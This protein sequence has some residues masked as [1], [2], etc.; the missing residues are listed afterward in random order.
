MKAELKHD[1][2]GA[3]RSG[4]YI[5]GRE[6][7]RSTNGAGI[8]QFCCLGVLCDLSGL[9]QWTQDEGDACYHVSDS[10]FTSTFNGEMCD[11]LGLDQKIMHTLW[12]KNDGVMTENRHTFN[13]IADYIEENVEVTP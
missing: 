2:V 10:M 12:H 9:G 3:L 11:I 1:W 4:D 6:H 13:E 8:D 5:Q 7:L